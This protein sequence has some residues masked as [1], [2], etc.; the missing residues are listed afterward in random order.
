MYTE[1]STAS[2]STR[3]RDAK[4]SV[5]K[6]HTPV[7]ALTRSMS[8]HG[9]DSSNNFKSSAATASYDVS[10]ASLSALTNTATAFSTV[11]AVIAPLTTQQ[12]SP[13]KARKGALKRTN[14]KI[15]NSYGKSLADTTMR[16]VLYDTIMQVLYDV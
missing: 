10:L 8:D 12:T 7:P 4:H 2:T 5:K 9:I 13:N 3:G 15:N 14:N 11:Q 6:P 1:L 16:S